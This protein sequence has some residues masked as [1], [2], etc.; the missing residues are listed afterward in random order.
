MA[1]I[2][3]TYR[4]D[5]GP[6]LPLEYD[7][8]FDHV[9]PPYEG[10]S[11]FYY[12]LVRNTDRFFQVI[13]ELNGVSQVVFDS[14]MASVDF[15]VTYHPGD[16]YSRR[17]IGCNQPDGQAFLSVIATDVEGNKIA[18]KYPFDFTQG[19]HVFDCS[20]M[21]S[22][23]LEALLLG[24][25][26]GIS[27]VGYIVHA[28]KGFT[29]GNIEINEL[30]HTVQGGFFE[31]SGQKFE[32]PLQ[33][34]AY[35]GQIISPHWLV[36]LYDGAGYPI[37]VMFTGQVT[38]NCN[39]GPL[40]VCLGDGPDTITTD[41]YIS[42]Q[43]IVYPPIGPDP[44]PPGPVE[45]VEPI[46]PIEPVEPIVEP[47]PPDILLPS[48]PVEPSTGCECEIYVGKQIARVATA[49][50][51]TGT[52]LQKV[53]TNILGTLKTIQKTQQ[54]NND[55][56]A[57][58]VDKI[59]ESLENLADDLMDELR[60]DFEA[61]DYTLGDIKDCLRLDPCEPEYPDGQTITEVLK[62]FVE[63]YEP[64]LV[65]VQEGLVAVNQDSDRVYR[66]NFK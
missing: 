30:Y 9:S 23:P 11:T 64:P 47:L 31:H 13:F 40:P 55:L 19:F 52:S 16:N 51:L 66:S 3:G 57:E 26:S 15:S 42:E 45:P 44:V 43:P 54:Q 61:L 32:I 6:E 59:N 63:Q 18:Q 65:E 1:D 56:L 12:H 2:I 22:S 10:N 38:L 17:V 28:P 60:Y 39:F 27:M 14:T 37:P 46:S 4:Q 7:I 29:A 20:S 33:E 5:Q 21:F 49:V 50:A 53:L 34:G 48:Q 24:G 36:S 62:E 41:E 58:G 35:K 25:S 8:G